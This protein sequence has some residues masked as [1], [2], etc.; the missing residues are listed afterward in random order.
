M[1]IQ[2]PST[3][4]I[5]IFGLSV[6]AAA[7]AL[8]QN[9]MADDKKAADKEELVKRLTGEGEK[10]WKITS[11]EKDGMKLP[12]NGVISTMKSDGMWTDSN[13]LSGKWRLSDDLKEII[14][15]YARYEMTIHCDLVELTARKM[16]V[17]FKSSFFAGIVMV[18]EPSEEA[19]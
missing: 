9:A 1:S 5:L 15:D 14:Y 8:T 16:V 6:A 19:S 11:A 7:L 13:G 2:R 3:L 4:F 18:M 17:K 10:K 12:A